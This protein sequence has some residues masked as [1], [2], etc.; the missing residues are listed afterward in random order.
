MYW[1]RRSTPA[2]SPSAEADLLGARRSRC[3]LPGT[4]SLDPILGD[5]AGIEEETEDL[6]APTTCR[7]QLDGPS[8]GSGRKTPSGPNAPS[9][10]TREYGT[11]AEWMR[12][13]RLDRKGDESPEL[14]ALAQHRRETSRVVSHATRTEVCSPSG[15]RS[16]PSM[17]S[18]KPF[19][20]HLSFPSEMTQ[21][22]F[23]SVESLRTKAVVSLVSRFIR[24]IF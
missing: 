20:L 24:L 5:A 8:A 10:Q 15:K 11:H 19:T 13:E 1:A 4:H 3:E 6:I 12:F 18:S 9:G 14:S 23:S 17:P 21:F 7:R 16:R 22:K 2:E